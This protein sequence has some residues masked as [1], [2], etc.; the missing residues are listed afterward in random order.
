MGA[1]RKKK[2]V[3]R[4]FF[5]DYLVYGSADPILQDF[6]KK[7]KKK[8]IFFLIN[9]FFKLFFF[10]QI[11]SC[12]SKARKRGGQINYGVQGTQELEPTYIA[13]EETRHGDRMID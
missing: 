10:L 7:K 2:I 4:P 8:Y 9:L 13:R 5:F 6:E 3:I 11:F 12:Q 1:A